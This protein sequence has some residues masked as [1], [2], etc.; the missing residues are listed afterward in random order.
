M[1]T[2]LSQ[3]IY[4]NMYAYEYEYGLHFWEIKAKFTAATHDMK[5]YSNTTEGRT[6]KI[7]N[8]Q[9]QQQQQQRNANEREWEW[10]WQN[11]RPKCN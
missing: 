11:R 1:R 3:Y 9:N 7:T 8:Q 4:I 6:H 5:V 10:Q 2:K